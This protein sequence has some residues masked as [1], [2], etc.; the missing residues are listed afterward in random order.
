MR[1]FNRKGRVFFFFVVAPLVSIFFIAAPWIAVANDRPMMEMPRVL[2]ALAFMGPCGL[3]LVGLR[4][5]LSMMM[6]PDDELRTVEED[7]RQIRLWKQYIQ[8]GSLYDWAG[9]V[10]GL[11]HLAIVLLAF[12]K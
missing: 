7:E 3:W 5:A 6:L 10:L 1:S 9:A 4:L 11:A 2:F 8:P 12:Q